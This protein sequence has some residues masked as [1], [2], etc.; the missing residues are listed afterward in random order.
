MGR[1]YLLWLR[2]RGVKRITV[3][4]LASAA[5]KPVSET[6][7]ILWFENVREDPDDTTVSLDEVIAK[8][9]L[10]KS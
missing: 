7:K 6:R 4:G 8:F 10:D 2:E 9:G 1:D 5:R 3:H